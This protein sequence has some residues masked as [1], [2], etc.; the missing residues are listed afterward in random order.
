MG[1]LG[2]TSRIYLYVAIRLTAYRLLLGY[3]PHAEARG[4]A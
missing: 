2:G 1:Y 3:P 4:Y